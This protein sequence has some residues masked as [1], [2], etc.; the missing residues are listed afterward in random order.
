MGR[1]TRTGRSVLLVAS[2]A[3]GIGALSLPGVRAQAPNTIHIV[4]EGGAAPGTYDITTSAPCRP[5]VSGPGDWAIEVN[6]PTAVPSWFSATVNAHDPQWNFLSI[7]FKIKTRSDR[8]TS[9]RAGPRRKGPSMTAA[10]R[11]S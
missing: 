5:D 4:L 2:L 11:P 1:S 10:S 6:D 7:N 9:W 8:R 3:L